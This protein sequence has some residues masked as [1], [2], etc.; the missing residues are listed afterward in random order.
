MACVNDIVAYVT[1]LSGHALNWDE[2]VRHGPSERN[3]TGATVCWMASPA[4][5]ESAGRQGQQL[6]IGHESLYYPY[7]LSPEA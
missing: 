7:Q 4:A 1:K 3:I 6:L 5:I 2:G